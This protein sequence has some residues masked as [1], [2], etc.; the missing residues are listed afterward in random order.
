MT[1]GNNNFFNKN[2]FIECLSGIDIG[3]NNLFGPNVVIIDHNHK[4][5][6]NRLI[7][8]Q[9]YKKGK[10]IIGSNVWIGANTTICKGVTIADN[11]VIGANSVVVKSIVSSGVYAGCP[12]VLIKNKGEFCD[13]S[14]EFSK[15]Q[16]TYDK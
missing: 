12:A 3:D 14:N 10:I 9:G 8:S 11:V 1:I 6:N 4:Y 7:S 15:N 5:D 16:A 2:I 13:T